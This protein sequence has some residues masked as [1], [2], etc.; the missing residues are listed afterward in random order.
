MNA[1]PATVKD[2]TFPASFDVESLYSNIPHELGIEAINYWLN[3]YPENIR[4]RFSKKFILEGIE[5]ILNNNSFYFDV[6]FYRQIKGTAMG[7]KFAPIYATL[8]I[9]YLEEKLYEKVDRIS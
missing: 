3:K 8:A 5:L 2:E 4:A 6:S 1:L 9:A 7:T